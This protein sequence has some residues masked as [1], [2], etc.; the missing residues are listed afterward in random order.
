MVTCVDSLV[1]GRLSNLYENWG[2]PAF[3]FMQADICEAAFETD[4][5]FD[6]VFHLASPASPPKYLTHPLETLRANGV[7][8][9]RL[10]KL[11]LSMNARFLFTSTSEVYGNPTAH[12]Q[13][14][15]DVGLTDPTN[16]RSVYSE[17]KRYGETLTSTFAR[18]FGCNARIV[19]LFNVYGPNSDPEDGRMIPNFFVQALTGQ[20]IT[21]YGEG[22]QTRSLCYVSDAI[23]GLIK[24]ME[25]DDL[26]GEVVNIG[27]PVEK[28]VAE[29]AR[30]VRE[31]VG[32]GVP[33]VPL[34]R[35][36][37][38]VVER[39]C[40]DISRARRLLDWSPLVSLESGLELTSHYF[41]RCIRAA[42]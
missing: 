2:N 40:P 3:R 10:L 15:T 26:R 38:D 18:S 36:R 35:D 30:S 12:P 7:G 32:T 16:P 14:E 42:A 6:Y 9:E 34:Q 19:R 28:T 13:S 22:K 25:S 27:N 5:R 21:V 39:R 37:S 31:L 17:G 41:S 1:T 23:D 24:A 8:T 33:I 11:S 29:Y 20:P 4:T